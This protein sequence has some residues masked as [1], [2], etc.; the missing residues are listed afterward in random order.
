LPPANIERQAPPWRSGV[1]LE[2]LANFLKEQG[3]VEALNLDGGSS[4]ALYFNGRTYYGRLNKEGQAVQRSIK[5]ALVVRR[6]P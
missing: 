1:T 6:Q 4:S 5:S 3:A 2:E